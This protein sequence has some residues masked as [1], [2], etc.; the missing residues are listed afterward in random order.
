MRRS[1]NESINIPRYY[2]YHMC[3]IRHTHTHGADVNFVTL[4]KKRVSRSVFKKKFIQ[5]TLLIAMKMA[6]TWKEKF[7][8]KST[9][10]TEENF[11][12][13]FYSFNLLMEC[14]SHT[15][16]KSPHL[17]DAAYVYFRIRTIGFR[18]TLFPGKANKYQLITCGNIYWIPFLMWFWPCT[19]VNM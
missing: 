4:K 17:L 9:R 12:R 19:L 5:I 3:C 7:S 18:P 15:P 14:M 16:W 2:L 8:V 11:H 10:C 6:N 13:A 1:H